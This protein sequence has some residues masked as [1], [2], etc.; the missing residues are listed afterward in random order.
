M[1]NQLYNPLII[2]FCSLYPSVCVTQFDRLASLLKSKE[3][4]LLNFNL[5]S[6]KQSK[7]LFRLNEVSFTDL[8]AV[9]QQ[10]LQVSMLQSY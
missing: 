10:S 9:A 8:S 4:G 2:S 5:H 6:S 3:L 1:I 7:V